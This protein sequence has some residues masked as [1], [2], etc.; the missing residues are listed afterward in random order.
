MGDRTARLMRVRR[1]AVCV[2][3]LTLLLSIAAP[4]FAM[5][6][7]RMTID[8]KTGGLLT[9]FTYQATVDE[10]ANLGRL[11]FL[12]P[13][14]FDTE[15]A[16]I[17]LTLLDGLQRIQ[18][19]YEFEVL[20]SG[21]V[22]LMF[23]PAVPAESNVFIEVYDVMIPIAGGTYEIP[24][25][26]EV[27]MGGRGEAREETGLTVKYDTPPREEALSRWLENQDAVKSWNSVTFLNTFFKPQHIV[28]AIPLLF[29]GWLISLSLVMIAFPISILGGLLVAFMKMA[30]VP[31]VRW[32]AS[33]YINIIRGTPLFLQ[34]FVVFIGFRTVGLRIPD[35][36]SAVAV[37]AF[38]SSAY[39]AEIFRAG[40]QSIS[41][42]QF[43]AAS[44]LGMSY[45]QA[46]Q[47]VI[48]PQTVRRV[49]PTMT[50]EFILLFKD[51]S[52]LAAVGIFELMMYSQNYVARNANLTAFMVAAGYYLIVT[53]PLINLVGRLETKL[54]QSE[55]GASSPPKGRPKRGVLLGAGDDP[56]PPGAP[57]PGLGSATGEPSMVDFDNS[58]AKHESR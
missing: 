15:D 4:A 2:V 23:D 45:W 5:T 9:R 38:N 34:I 24:V 48:V 33:T 51:T 39:L 1:A 26:Y 40:I 32:I 37:L 7:G 54:A 42:G 10:D 13:E 27:V 25:E 58:A 6:D 14:G 11:D 29:K 50:S 47:Y 20:E 35:F 17:K 44:S 22:R 43:E 28:V 56:V 8:R 36:P 41:K 19:D 31:P 53:I 30:K 12:F 49:L 46:M 57:A 21:A 18:A 52:L 55:H 3:L 16:Y